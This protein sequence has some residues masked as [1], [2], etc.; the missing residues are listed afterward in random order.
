MWARCQ[1]KPFTKLWDTEIDRSVTALS[2]FGSSG[3]Q[4][5]QGTEARDERM[6]S[7]A[8]LGGS[9]KADLDSA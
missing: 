6:M 9:E 8:P 5:V 3:E 1:Y 7:K 2:S 4:V